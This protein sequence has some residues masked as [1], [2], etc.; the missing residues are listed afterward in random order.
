PVYVD[1]GDELGEETEVSLPGFTESA[2]FE[3]FKEKARAFLRQHLDNEAIQKLRMNEPLTPDDLAQ[4][5]QI[6]EA[7]GAG[8]SAAIQRASEGGLDVFVKT[9]VGLDR[10]AAKKALNEVVANTMLTAQ[11]IEF[12]NMIVDYLTEH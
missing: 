10:E 7:S 11:Q 4:L 3:R 6:L 2:N 1:F 9:L 12:M 5:Q 8:D